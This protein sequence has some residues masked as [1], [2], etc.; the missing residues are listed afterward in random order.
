MPD[1][2]ADDCEG[3]SLDALSAAFA[4][5]LGEPQAASDGGPVKADQ[6]NQPT[7]VVLDF[8]EPIVEAD[9]LASA[10]GD[11]QCEIGPLTILESLL[12][13]GDPAGGPIAAERL[14]SVMRGVEPDE[15]Y[16]LVGELNQRYEQEGRPYAVISE[17]AGY[18]LA[19]RE[20]HRRVRDKFQGR[21]KQA[22]LSQ[23]AVDVLALVAYNQP[24]AADEIQKLRGTPSGAVLGQLVRRQ[25]LSVERPDPAT[26]V[27]HYRTTG[28]FLDIFG[29]A[30]LD[31]LPT[32]RDLDEK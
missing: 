19:L 22:R 10:P 27:L 13:V 16:E 1:E 9:S 7:P 24:V 17:G 2:N 29:L 18:R 28:R 21:V 30:S 23:A 12:F 15:V 5:A 31:D 8:A 3:L 26:R 25:L 11:E 32:S 14:A 6:A 20:E 4:A